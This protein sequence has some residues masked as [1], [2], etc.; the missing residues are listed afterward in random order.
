MT[1]DSAPRSMLVDPELLRGMTG[2]ATIYS[3]TRPLALVAY[4]ALLAAFVLNAIVLSIVSGVDE[5]QATTLTWTLVAIAA[6]AVASIVFTRAQVRRAI[7][8]AMPSGSSV[9]VS[10]G[11]E[12]IKLFAKNGVSDMAYSTFRAVRVGRHAAILQLRGAS[13][14]TAV[15][16]ALLSDADIAL[17]K[18]KI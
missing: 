12:T 18:Q 2:D 13:I 8:T 10:L 14:V 11:D 4:T 3:L 16:R 9:G 17:L 15:P 7:T 1:S 6:F 5:E